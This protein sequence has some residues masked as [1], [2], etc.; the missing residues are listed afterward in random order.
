[1]YNDKPNVAIE[2]F[3]HLSKS[4]DL[5]D[6]LGFSVRENGNIGDVIP[7]SPSARAGIVSGSQ[8]VAVN[9]RKYSTDTLRQVVKASTTSTTPIEL[10]VE[11]GEFYTT[12][13]IP[14]TGGVRYPHLERVS[15]KPD[16]LETLGRPLAKTA[17]KK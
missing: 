6:S 4:M 5:S 15:G 9:G 13:R 8:I 12:A 7:N 17:A 3:E 11:S 2:H 1:M 10:I 16:L 14:Y